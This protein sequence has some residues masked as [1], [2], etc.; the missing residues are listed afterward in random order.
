[1]SSGFITIEVHDEQFRQYLTNVELAVHNMWHTLEEVAKIVELQ[2]RK[3]V[4]VD[5]T[6]L[7]QSFVAF[8]TGE[9]TKG[10]LEMEI[11]YSTLNSPIPPVT[12]FDYAGVTH[13]GYRTVNGKKVYF[14]F[15][16]PSAKPLY[17]WWGMNSAERSGAFELIEGDYLSIWRKGG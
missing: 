8:P 10:F 11:G 2:S 14:H 15:K 17:L 9:A 13:Q 1:M 12:S 3:F 4:P 5:T 16:K 7:E 6:R